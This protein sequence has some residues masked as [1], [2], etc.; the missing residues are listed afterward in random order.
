MKPN[1]CVY[2]A[3]R[4]V[5]ENQFGINNLPSD[6]FDKYNEGDGVRLSIVAKVIN[7][8]LIDYGVGVVGVYGHFEDESDFDN[9]ELLRP[10]QFV[11]APCI[12]YDGNCHA[13][14]VLPND[15]VKEA[16]LVIKLGMLT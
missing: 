1:S 7:E 6:V 9:P 10:P 11:D 8:S 4:K 12:A 2:E 15:G 13:Y 3:T 16:S 5:V 14:A